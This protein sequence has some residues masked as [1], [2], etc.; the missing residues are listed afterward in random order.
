MIP[1]LA[2]Q[3]KGSSVA[4]AAAQVIAAGWIQSRAW[5]LL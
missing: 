4:T 1:G 5:E 3:V 2:Q